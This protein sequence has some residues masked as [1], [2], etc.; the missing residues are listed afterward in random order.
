MN[1]TI[2]DM[3]DREVNCEDL[4]LAFLIANFTRLPPI[5][6]IHFINKLNFKKQQHK[7]Q[8]VL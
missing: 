3:V 1:K 7:Y 6:V 2:R 5:Q 4:A 8:F